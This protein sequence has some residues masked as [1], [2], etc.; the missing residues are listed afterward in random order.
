MDARRSIVIRCEG[1]AGDGII[2][3]GKVL[4]RA[5][6]R[7]G[8]HV[9]TLASF[10]A[11]VRGGQSSLQLK[12]GVGNVLSP[13]DD[14]EVLVALNEQ[15]VR[16]V[17]SHVTAAGLVLGPPMNGSTPAMAEGVRVLPIDYD[18]LSTEATGGTRSKNIVA[19]GVL[20]A[21]IGLDEEVVRKVVAELFGK[22]A[23]DAE[24][25]NVRACDAGAK[26][27]AASE[28]GDAFR[29][30]K[31]DGVG[32][33]LLSGNQAVALGAVAGGVRFY[34]GYP[35]TPA[36]EIMEEIADLLPRVGGRMLQV[37]DEI[38]SLGMCIGASY[39]GVPS[40]TATSGPGL[41]L[42]VELIGLAGISETPLVIVDV[43]RAGPS[44]G[45]PTKDGQADLDLAVY[46]THGEVP[47][48]VLAAQTVADCF[49]QTVAAANLAHEYQ[50]PA[51]LLTSMSLSHSLQTVEVP[52][53]AA[54]KVYQET[55]YAG[56]ADGE[57]VRFQPTEDGR[58]SRRSKPGTPGGIYRTGGLEHNDRGHP[59]FDPDQRREMVRRRKLR[60]QALVVASDAAIEPHSLV[61]GSHRVGVTSWGRAAAIAREVVTEL[62]QEGQDIGYLFPH[63][64]WPLPK[65]TI[66]RFLAS[67][68]RTL[69]VCEANEN[70]QFANLLRANFATELGRA[71]IEVVTVNKDDGN[72]FG[73]GE[74]REALRPWLSDGTATTLGE[75]GPKHPLDSAA[76]PS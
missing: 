18:A 63:V 69:V 75:V 57:F 37:E 22:R 11:E 31:S 51:L 43:Q 33:L 50:V 73:P 44:T 36:T 8:Y 65:A 35:I 9:V 53:L 21:L 70:Q 17:A 66:R 47:R 71:G 34:A 13:G 49:S 26:A 7:A 48:V 45:M 3:L 28:I 12:I 6:A 58:P 41:S 15:G 40:M 74:I 62:R 27:A 55:F 25:A 23:A 10:L 56:P 54:L 68:L 72:P 38:A 29:L 60:S 76:L 2:S 20:A 59:S 4:A 61:L 14:P 39:G 1:S 24:A 67:G 46:G 5:A 19:V 64:V 42:M 52:D 16:E 32:K 30:P